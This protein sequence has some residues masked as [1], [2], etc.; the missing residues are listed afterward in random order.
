MTMKK[1]SN[2]KFSLVYSFH[3]ILCNLVLGVNFSKV[4]NGCFKILLVLAQLWKSFSQ[5]NRFLTTL[6]S[7]YQNLQLKY[8][9]LIRK[10]AAVD[11][12]L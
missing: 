5:R 8:L 1:I 11:Y 7:D 12:G 3:I 6:I 2:S 9:G 4:W 10:E